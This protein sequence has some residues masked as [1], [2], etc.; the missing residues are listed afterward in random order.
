MTW[1]G[2]R[3][4]FFEGPPRVLYRRTGAHYVDAC[5]AAIVLNGVAVSAFG[6]ITLVLYVDVRAGELALFAAA[7]AAW[8]FV[9][10]LVAAACFRRAAAPVQVWL[11]GERGEDA[12]LRAWSAGARLAVVLLRRPSLYA[13]GA[14]GAGATAV[15]LA[16]R[17]G[18]P[19]IEA[20]CCS[21]RPTC[22]TCT[23]RC[24]ATWA[25]SS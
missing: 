17:L 21:P 20:A 6:V 1:R 16:T 4:G 3:R 12:A 25:S 11:S 24:C 2:R 18:L 13:I 7:S 5:A 15:V 22:C 23:R 8:Y 14:A 19:A 9:E 10:G